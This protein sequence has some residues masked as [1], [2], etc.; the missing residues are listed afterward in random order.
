MNQNTYPKIFTH[1]NDHKS[2]VVIANAEQ[3]AQLPPEYLPEV[4]GAGGQT[5]SGADHAANVMLSPEYDALLAD[6]EK[7]EQDRATFAQLVADAQRDASQQMQ[8]LADERAKLTAGY[9]ESMA[10]L[11]ADRATLNADRQEL[12]DQRQPADTGTTD[13]AAPAPA[14]GPAKRVRTAKGE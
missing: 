9:K 1:R 8:D 11:E 13:Q 10:Q 7:L 14:A 2:Q 3:E 12:E 6:R 4:V 5:I